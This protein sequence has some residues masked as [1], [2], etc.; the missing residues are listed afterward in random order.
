M[1]ARSGCVGKSSWPHLGPFQTIC[2]MDRT[3]PNKYVFCLFSLVGQWALFTRFGASM[4]CTEMPWDLQAAPSA[5][6]SHTFQKHLPFG[7]FAPAATEG[8]AAGR[9]SS[10]LPCRHSAALMSSETIV[11]RRARSARNTV[12]RK[13]QCLK[14]LTRSLQSWLTFSVIL[15]RRWSAT[16]NRH[17]KL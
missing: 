7:L 3:N 10:T 6:P 9:N 17:A 4:A 16:S 8:A 14:F 15:S 5:K 11:Q 2:S 13:M 1:S 12:S